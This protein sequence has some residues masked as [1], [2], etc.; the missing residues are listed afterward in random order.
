MPALI[1][2]NLPET[3]DRDS[4]L[5]AVRN[6]CSIEAEVRALLEEAVKPQRPSA[7]SGPMGPMHCMLRRLRD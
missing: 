6:G 4:C 2:R 5:R 1:V 3:V 7:V